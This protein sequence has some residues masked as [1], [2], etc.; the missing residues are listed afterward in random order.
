[1]DRWPHLSVRSWRGALE[2]R[3]PGYYEDSGYDEG[4]D[5]DLLEAREAIR[6]HELRGLIVGQ[7]AEIEDLFVTLLSS[8][9]QQL[10]DVLKTPMSKR[11]TAGKVL[12]YIEELLKHLA[13]RTDLEAQ[14][15]TLRRIISRRNQLVH[16]VVRIGFVERPWGRDAVISY[17]TPVEPSEDSNNNSRATEDS[18]RLQGRQ[19]TEDLDEEF[20]LM[21]S[22]LERILNQSYEALEAALDIWEAVNA[23]RPQ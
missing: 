17:F 11:P 23:S 10:K 18:Q 22:D 4:L 14:I 5:D 13:K 15:Q 9:R 2:R 7:V 12:E 6:M 3:D 20:V 16:S 1:M 21:E 8:Q 19:T